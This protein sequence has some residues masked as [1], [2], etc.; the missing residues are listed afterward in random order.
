LEKKKETA[1]SKREEK[2]KSNSSTDLYKE[3]RSEVHVKGSSTRGGKRKSAADFRKF[4]QWKKDA[5]QDAFISRE[6]KE[7]EQKEAAI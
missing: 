7:K 4:R 5:I 1:P 3:K 6:G 2:K